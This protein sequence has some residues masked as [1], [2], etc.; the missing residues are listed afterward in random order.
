VYRMRGTTTGIDSTIVTWNNETFAIYDVGGSRS[1]RKKWAYCPH[2]ASIIIYPVGICHFDC[3]M[4]DAPEDNNLDE[5]NHLYEDLMLFEAIVKSARWK[6]SKFVLLFTKLDVLIELMGSRRLEESMKACFPEFNGNTADLL[7]LRD[8][9]EKKFMEN[10]DDE[11][12]KNITVLFGNLVDPA[13]LTVK[14]V[15][16]II[17][18]HVT[19][20]ARRRSG[21]S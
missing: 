4:P 16:D 20:K 3:G 11:L 1:E 15:L 5:N 21:E 12:Q 7:Q 17:T 9:F 2:G 8:F 13:G 10:I 6:G 19:I 14:L 18:K